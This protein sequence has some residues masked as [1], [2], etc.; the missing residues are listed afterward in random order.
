V[1]HRGIADYQMWSRM[2]KVSIFLIPADPMVC[3]GA[4]LLETDGNRFFARLASLSSL[5][6]NSSVTRE[7]RSEILAIASVCRCRFRNTLAAIS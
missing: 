6:S 2:P 1:N 7:Q 4:N 5:D 3:F